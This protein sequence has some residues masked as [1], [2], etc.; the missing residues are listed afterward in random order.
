MENNGGH[1]K[2]LAAGLFFILGLAL[3]VVSVFIIGIDRGLTEPKFQIIALFNEVGGLVEVPPS[4][5]P[6]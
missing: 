6:G 3:I 1:F 2:K 5:F 4:V